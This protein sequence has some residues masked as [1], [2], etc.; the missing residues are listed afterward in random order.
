MN[1]DSWTDYGLPSVEAFIK[2]GYV[3]VGTDYQGLGGGGRHQYAVAASQARDVIDSIRAASSV[4]AS[5][6]GKKAIVYGWSQG[7]GATI[8][9]ASL[10][11]YIALQNT[12]SDNIH[13]RCHGSVR[14]G[15]AGCGNGLGR[16]GF[17]EADGRTDRQV[18]R[19]RVLISPILQ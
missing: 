5:G 8:G 3:V 6:A 7:G 2:E 9:A 12:V 4:K 11:E 16:V 15:R 18:F 13:F 1:G 14:H 19:Q 10:P 17:G